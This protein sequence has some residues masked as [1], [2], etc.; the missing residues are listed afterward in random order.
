MNVLRYHWFDIG[1]GLALAAGIAAI[2]LRPVSLGLLLWL[3][4]IA[5]FVHQFEEYR[6]PGYFPGV[7]N[8]ALFQSDR[9]DRYPLNANTSLIVNVVVGWLSFSAAVLAGQH[10]I[11]L[12][13]ATMMVSAGNVVAHVILFNV[14]P[15]T[16]YNPGMASA[17][18]LFL[19]ISVLFFTSLISGGSAGTIDWAVGIALGVVL[20]YVGILKLIDWLKNEHSPYPFPERCM[21]PAHHKPAAR[22]R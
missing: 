1:L 21:L 15:R 12:G 19:P 10:A 16:I 7:I 11:W 20:N 14:R 13:I 17:V 3:N 5:L 2:V 18:L 22:E 9:P 4:L 6:F 8:M